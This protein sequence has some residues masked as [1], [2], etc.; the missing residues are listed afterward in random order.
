M[1]CRRF[2]VRGGNYIERL[3]RRW[4]LMARMY[5]D[6]Q[7]R[8]RLVRYE[9][10]LGDKMGVIVGLAGELGLKPVNDITG[11]VSFQFQPAG[12]RNVDLEDF[13]GD[14]LG[15]VERVCHVEMAS[16]GYPAASRKGV[17]K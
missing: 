5:L 8:M 12:D 11:R 7:E 17:R 14:N 4:S 13:F 9:D 1:G 15:A 6:N 10:F 2:G 16:L 3:S